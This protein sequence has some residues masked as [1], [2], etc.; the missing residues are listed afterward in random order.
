M[1]DLI[2][3]RLGTTIWVTVVVIVA[4]YRM[5]P[6]ERRGILFNAK[7]FALGIIGVLLSMYANSAQPDAGWRMAGAISTFITGAALI[8]LLGII[9]FRLV[10][11]A[12]KFPSPRI[13]Q[14]VTVAGGQLVWG[15]VFM[16][17]QGVNLNGLIATSAV[18]TGV[19]GFSMQDTLGNILGGLSI[20]LDDSIRVGE[21]I[22][23]DGVWGRVV[24]TR[25]RYTAIET[26]NW[27]ILLIPNSVMMKNKII[28]QGRHAGKPGYVRRQIPFTVDYR[29]PPA[30]VINTVNEGLRAAQIPYVATDPQ[31]NTVFSDFGDS[32]GKYTVRYWVTDPNMDIPT[33]SK[34]RMNIFSTLQRDGISPALPAHAVFVTELTEEYRTHRR[35]EELARR[36]EML[37]SIEL[38]R[39]LT[40]DEMRELAD[41]LLPAPFGIGSIMTR[42]GATANWLYI[43]SE[44]HADVIVN[45]GETDERKVATLAPGNVFGEMGLLT[46]EP[47]S[48]TVIAQTDVRAW[49]LDKESFK[50]ILEAR[51]EIAREM[52]LILAD[53]RVG[54]QSARDQTSGGDRNERV[55][56]M[57]SSILDGIR[58]FFGLHPME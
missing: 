24:E 25:W 22:V 33:D 2:Q 6:H 18:L 47:R 4:L 28:I 16:Q 36:S 27:E 14:D 26:A 11:P 12:A 38:F 17:Q 19:I 53:R 57:A 55:A 58:G 5:A 8:G 3:Q 10:L 20:Q 44:G 31:A 7:I 40:D 34:V 32:V 39:S 15:L 9:A 50:S 45:M 21:Y 41:R 35:S 29:H 37:R 30:K 56:S 51:P 1:F 23:V 54:L 49:R 46:G 43:L 13:L 48:A 42:Q 52:S